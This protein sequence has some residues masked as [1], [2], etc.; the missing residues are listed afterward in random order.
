MQKFLASDVIYSQRVVPLMSSALTAQGIHDLTVAPSSVLAGNTSWLSPVTVTQRV[1]G[2]TLASQ[3]GTN[4]P[5]SNGHALT[6]VSVNGV[7]L[8]PGNVT[9]PTL[10]YTTGMQ[11]TLDVLNTGAGNV[12]DATAEIWFTG[13]GLPARDLLTR[14][15]IPETF[16]GQTTLVTIP[17]ALTPPLGR[18]V[19]LHAEVRPLP[20]ETDSTN[21]HL[22]FVVQFK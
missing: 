14:V 18:A 19:R 9:N 11:F 1:L 21:N 3:G 12:H 13:A 5:G 7:T 8:T 15:T 22:S 2:Y 20:G 16:P 6:G 10:T 4:V 17:L